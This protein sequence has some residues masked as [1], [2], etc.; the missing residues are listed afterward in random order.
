MPDFLANCGGLVR[1][2]AERRGAGD[3]EVADRL[4]EAE[5]RTRAI[6]AEAQEGGEPPVVVAERHA[7]ARI[8]AAAAVA[9]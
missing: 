6:L 9:A 8:D 1:A 5:V 2:D 3:E 4:A 7:R